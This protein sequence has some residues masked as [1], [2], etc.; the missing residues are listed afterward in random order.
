MG[1][2]RIFVSNMAG[3]DYTALRRWGDVIAPI[4]TGQLNFSS[5][6]R[7]KFQ[8]AEGMKDVTVDDYLALSGA[9]VVNVMAALI[10]FHTHGLVKLLNYDKRTGNYREIT[11]TSSNI[12]ELVSIV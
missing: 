1:S 10:W 9:A 4:T 7:V 3:H 5:L 6:D 2:P 12:D 8:V 11:I